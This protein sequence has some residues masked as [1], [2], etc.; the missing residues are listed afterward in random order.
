MEMVLGRD[1]TGRNPLKTGLVTASVRAARRWAAHAEK[2]RNPLKTGLVT[3][4][5]KMR[6]VEGA[7]LYCTVAI[8]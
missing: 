1:Y 3:A 4:R 7:K 2:G 8:P 5:W 6:V